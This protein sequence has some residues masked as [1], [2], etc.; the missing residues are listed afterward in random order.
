MFPNM[1]FNM[2][3]GNNI[4]NNSATNIDNDNI[5]SIKNPKNILCDESFNNNIISS[6]TND[7]NE[8]YIT[9]NESSI[10]TKYTCNDDFLF[11]EIIDNVLGS[12]TQIMNFDSDCIDI[13]LSIST[14]D[15][16]TII[17]YTQ[18][19]VGPNNIIDN[20]FDD[21]HKYNLCN[22]ILNNE[23][24]NEILNNENSNEILNNGNG[25]E[26][27]NNENGN[28]ILDKK[29]K[30]SEIE[31]LYDKNILY[32]IDYFPCF[33]NENSINNISSESI[34]NKNQNDDLK[35]NELTTSFM[36]DN[37]DLKKGDIFDERINYNEK[38]KKNKNVIVRIGV[39]TVSAMML[40]S[41]SWINNIIY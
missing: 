27:L 8:M 24:S 29:N 41:G 33:N 39:I 35:L 17:D 9:C 1:T 38:S 37:E 6:I 30:N 19:T 2:Q 28:E 32:P 12:E 15:D 13:S 23:N 40:V 7:I 21:P 11:K 25:N 16:Y 20:Y 14:N 18:T 22:E 10:N 3:Y 5:S 36:F 34:I 26:I 4:K 31:K